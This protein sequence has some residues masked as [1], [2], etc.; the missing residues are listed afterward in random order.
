MCNAYVF[1]LSKGQLEANSMT[2]AREVLK[3]KREYN[4][5]IFWENRYLTVFYSILLVTNNL[6]DSI[7]GCFTAILLPYNN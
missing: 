2:A 3:P 4:S 6:M 7:P 5:F 1:I